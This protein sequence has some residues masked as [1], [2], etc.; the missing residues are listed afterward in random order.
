MAA[1]LLPADH[2]LSRELAAQVAAPLPPEI[3]SA[4][5][6][7][8]GLVEL[9]VR[10]GAA[11]GYGCRAWRERVYVLPLR[12]GVDRGESGRRRQS[13][14]CVNPGYLTEC[15]I[16]VTDVNLCMFMGVLSVKNFVEKPKTHTNSSRL[17]EKT[18]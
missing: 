6:I 17:T 2:E 16:P 4:T 14:G 18:L 8:P 15:S 12:N 7:A 10:A 9:R 5:R 11:T 13:I 1:L 3:T